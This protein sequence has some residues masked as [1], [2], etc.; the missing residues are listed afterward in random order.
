M[1]W[2][3][4]GGYHRRS[5]VR[6]DGD[7]APDAASSAAFA[8][9]IAPTADANA[10]TSEPSAAASG[11]NAPTES[12]AAPSQLPTGTRADKPAHDSGLDATIAAP[13][14]Q[15]P[16]ARSAGSAAH[17]S[18]TDATVAAPV[19][20]EL[21]PLPEVSAALYEIDKEIARGGMGKIVAAEDRRLGRPVALKSLLD[22]SSD[23]I[24]R[25]QREALI[26]ARLQ[27][28]GIVPVY[29]AGRWPN[30]EPFFA[31]KLVSGRPL[32]KVIAEATR[33][34]DRLAIIP[35]LAA[36]CDAI[37]YAHSQRIIH[38]DLKPGN[39][40]LGDFGET[41]VIDWGLAK[42]LDSDHETVERTL[43]MRPSQPAIEKQTVSRSDAST[44]TV[45]GAVMGTPAYMAPE[46]ARGE[47]VDQRAD[48]FSLGAM[49]YHTL[50][51]VPPYNARTATD[52]IAAAARGKI[53]PLC[54]RERRA[55]ADLVAI[56]ERAM[57]QSPYDRYPHAG[58]LAD[59]LRRFLTGQL[60]DAHRY[61]ALQRIVRFG[62]KHRAAVTIAAIA[63]LTT[64]IGGTVA[65][66]NIVTARD[67]AERERS[68][69]ITRKQAAEKLIDY[70]FSDMK[71]R[72]DAAG[73]LDMLSG[74]GTEVKRYYAMLSRMPGGMPRED[75]IRMA[76][77]IQLIGQ[78]EHKS[79]KPDQAL[80][81][82]REARERLLDVVG[83]SKHEDTRK[84]RRLIARLDYEAGLIFIER[85][86][87][88]DAQR[89][90]TGAQAMY[91]QL[92][93]EEPTSKVVLL[94]TAD[95]HDRLGDLLRLEGKIDEAFEQ[96]SLGKN[97]RAR[98][99]S[100]G[101]GRAS[102][103][104]LALSTSHFKLASVF[105]N[106]GES[107][108]A[109]DEF[110]HALRLRETLLE[111]QPDHV[112]YQE[113]VL[114]VL[115]ELAALQRQLGDEAS[116]IRSYRRAVPL[117]RQLV[118]RDP[119]NTEWQYQRGNL[120]SD[121]GFAL[122]DSGQFVEGLAEIESSIEVH[123]D[124]VA[125]DGKSAR[126]QIALSRSHTRGGDA[127]V[128]LG[129]TADGV[130]Q[131]RYAL[132]L[133][134]ELLARD[135]RSVAYRRSIAWSHAKLAKAF[136]ID[137]EPVRAIESHEQAL[138][139]RA[140]LVAESPSQGGFKNELASTEIGLGRLLAARDAKRA[141]TLLQQGIAR[142]RMLVA[143]D[144]INNEWK[145]TLTQGLLARGE[146]ARARGD[147]KARQVVLTEAAAI[148]EDAALRSPQNA[149]WP[150]YVAE[151]HAGLA[152]V[153]AA[154]ND[155]KAAAASWKRV[156][157]TLEPLAKAG[158]LPAPRKSLLERARARN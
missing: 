12:P 3:R 89:H 65:V 105:Q 58:Q 143:G 35:R 134:Q 113:G 109:V 20:G 102:E 128:Y 72:L 23:Q 83:D 117:S 138:A 42:D 67:Q 142:A 155:R 125:R 131:Y 68:I 4:H 144:M 29:E 99:A 136:T 10:T 98:A 85:G 92:K 64:S 44:L 31:M 53:V 5:M 36:A 107:G 37:A 38:R 11:S 69:A 30:G 97:E 22:P 147:T 76:E 78:A 13:S 116:A 46:Q 120:L 122:I 54:E 154:S 104:V 82:W 34:E 158:R 79:G 90:F 81:T 40:L 24:T 139:L 100:Q 18:G 101:S 132:E 49:L 103:E 66:S 87:L 130:A 55:P 146:L 41:V 129:R 2:S 25:F 70:M 15:R 28:P 110:R 33:L 73:R 141:E 74:L 140:Q 119:T 84:L 126:Y 86:K 19:A 123:K 17:D 75:E 39:V 45:A 7:P 93:T 71:D 150:G 57:A 60:V 152:E 48:V 133:R 151:S 115:R 80:A 77:A 63:I 21:P 26:T 149:H 51:G 62:K 112:R 61:T 121:L 91:E 106:R 157:E 96:Y 32:D 156:V 6:K 1:E 124:L 153:A 27:H 114:E 47:P 95:V 137:G 56:V 43:R 8:A 88:A 145:E 127:H 16:G 94:E 148:A 59:E 50:A 118:Q 14:S 52:V 9:T 108:S 111:S 135:P